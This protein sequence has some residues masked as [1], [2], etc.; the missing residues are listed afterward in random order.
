[1]GAV[2][3]HTMI[4]GETA[5][6]DVTPFFSDP[7]GDLLG[8]EAS[9]S[10]AQVMGVSVSGSTVTVAALEPGTATVSVTASDHEGLAATQTTI[11]QGTTSILTAV[12]DIDAFLD[13]CPTKDPAYAQIRQDFEL[14]VDGEV[15]T[16]PMVCTE[17]VSQ[18]ALDRE[19]TYP[20]QYFQLL[21]LAYYMNDGTEGRLP[22]TDKGLYE[23]MASNISGVNYKTAP[24][25]GYCCDVIDGKLYVSR[26]LSWQ[27]NDG[28]SGP[29]IF[30]VGWS[31][32][33]GSLA[34]FAHE[35]R[36]AD[37]DDPGHVDG[38][39]VSGCDAT[40]DLSNLGAYGVHYWV[41]ANFATGHLNVGIGC[42][43]QA[44]QYV[45]HNTWGA[46][47]FLNTFVTNPPPRVNPQPP[48]GG[49]C[50]PPDSPWK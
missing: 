8:Y 24:G 36:H 28:T 41:H 43:S 46:N 31:R 45:A 17:P 25:N 33:S 40:Y 29:L 23:W 32:I 47:V 39:E 3:P 18:M 5:T 50:I 22:W 11:V 10:D 37:D 44:E 9:S 49:P 7:D 16:D 12:R 6:V 38:C 34:F 4:A 48:Y 1:M 42:S 14:R 19:T 15:V 27:D 35:T 26:P 13:Q 21:R 2:P 20:L 30:P